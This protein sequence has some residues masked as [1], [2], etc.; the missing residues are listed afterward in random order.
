MFGNNGNKVVLP[1]YKAHIKSAMAQAITSGD[2]SD[3]DLTVY[4]GVGEEEDFDTVYIGQLSI[5]VAKHP[6]SSP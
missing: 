3:P 6:K 4:R 2:D 5:P 1:S